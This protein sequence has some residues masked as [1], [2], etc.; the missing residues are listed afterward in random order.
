MSLPSRDNRLIF[1]LAYWRKTLQ[2]FTRV[3]GTADQDGN[4]LIGRLVPLTS[5]VE[6]IIDNMSMIS[7]RRVIDKFCKD[8]KL[9]KMFKISEFWGCSLTSSMINL[10]PNWPD[11]LQRLLS[12][13]PPHQQYTARLRLKQCKITIEWPATLHRYIF[14]CTLHPSSGFISTSSYPFYLSIW[15]IS[16]KYSIVRRSLSSPWGD[17]LR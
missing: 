4:A 1:E 16:L 15:F 11:W 14:Y 12:P 13:Q 9:K 6:E 8:T 10:S 3:P 2:C 7:H 17:R 5:T